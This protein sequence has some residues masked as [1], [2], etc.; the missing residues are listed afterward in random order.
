MPAKPITWRIT[1]IGGKR[2]HYVGSVLA[3]DD[4]AAIEKAI[5][6]FEV[7]EL[8]RRRRLVAQREP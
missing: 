8:H 5:E 1:E 7:T 4:K 2:G 6:E 3:A